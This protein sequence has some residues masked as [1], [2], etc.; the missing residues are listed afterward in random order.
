MNMDYWTTKIWSALSKTH[1]FPANSPMKIAVESNWSKGYDA[2]CAIIVPNHPLVIE[3]PS[4][5]FRE[6]PKQLA[7]QSILINCSRI[8]QS[9][10]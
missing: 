2:L 4:I 5:L 8:L 6:T 1:V 3:Q 7:S 10:M 9:G